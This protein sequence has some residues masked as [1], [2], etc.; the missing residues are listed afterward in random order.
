M[1]RRSK[2]NENKM[3]GR[4]CDGGS[5]GMGAGDGDYHLAGAYVHGHQFCCYS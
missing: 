4:D 5:E 1:V 2:A 3:E